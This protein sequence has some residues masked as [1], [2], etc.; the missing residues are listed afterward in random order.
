MLELSQKPHQFCSSPL[1]VE[2]SHSGYVTTCFIYRMV[3]VLREQRIKFTSL[4]WLWQR[5]AFL[6]IWQRLL[7]LSFGF[8]ISSRFPATHT[9]CFWHLWGAVSSWLWQVAVWSPFLLAVFCEFI[10]H[11]V[12][13][14][15]VFICWPL[16]S[17]ASP[18]FEMTSKIT[19]LLSVVWSE[20][21]YRLSAALHPPM[22]PTLPLHDYL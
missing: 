19:N 14:N 13:D 6:V 21:T 9:L 11:N 1:S 7:W 18:G 12:E 4:V 17:F 5:D 15:D 8:D 20:V 16:S 2:W 22:P 10:E 3:A